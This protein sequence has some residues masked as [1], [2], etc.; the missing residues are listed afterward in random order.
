[1]PL[2]QIENWNGRPIDAIQTRGGVWAFPDYSDGV[3]RFPACCWPPPEIVQKL[4]RSDKHIYFHPEDQT[5]ITSKLGYYV[6]LQSAHSE[7]SMVWS[8][9]GVLSRA[10]PDLRIRWAKWF[11]QLCGCEQDARQCEVTLWRRVPHPDNLAAGGPEIDAVIQTE[12]TLIL[13]EAKWRSAESRW[14]G[15]DG[16]SGQLELRRRFLANY[17]RNVY[18]DRKLVVAVVLLEGL[19]TPNKFDQ[20]ASD[21][22]CLLWRS[23]AACPVHP[24]GDE[25]LRYYNWKRHLI[26]RKFGVAAPG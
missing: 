13:V 14:Q 20:D 3:I 25:F 6:D 26:P 11:L 22:V 12:D 18:H 21:T 4:F 7:D 17:G 24:A 2:Q 9:F 16:H 1:M 10:A 19:S 23:L 5:L 15:V 8:Y